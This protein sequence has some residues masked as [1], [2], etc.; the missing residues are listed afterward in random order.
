ARGI[1]A[2]RDRSLR[3]DRGCPAPA[4]R[5][6]WWAPILARERARYAAN[7]E[8]MRERDRVYD[9][10]N[11]ERLNANAA[12]RRSHSTPRRSSPPPRTSPPA[13]SSTLI[14]RRPASATS[15]VAVASSTSGIVIALGMAL[16]LAEEAILRQQIR[17]AQ[18]ELLVESIGESP[19]QFF[20]V[21]LSVHP[22][23]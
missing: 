9:A 22:C 12:R 19:Q 17:S 1:A 2:R 8:L 21:H 6:A 18:P 7:P 20:P 13:T 5:S 14:P 11:N 16:P 10:A 15:R 23:H 3:R 4:S